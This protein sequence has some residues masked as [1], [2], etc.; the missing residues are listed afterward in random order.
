MPAF[1][2]VELLSFKELTEKIAADT[3]KLKIVNFWATW[4][5]PCVAELPYFS[6]LDSAYRTQG[7]KV[8]LVSLDLPSQLKMKVIPFVKRRKITRPVILLNEANPND[9]IDKVSSRWSG[10]IPATWFLDTHN[11]TI[12]F[13]V[14]E[15]SYEELEKLVQANLRR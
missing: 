4:C 2:Q 14:G 5:V 8:W 13:H 11:Q 9:W 3:S 6:K 15:Y 7:I 10:T 1:G 12:H